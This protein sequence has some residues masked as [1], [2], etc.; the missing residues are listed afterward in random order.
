MTGPTP[1]QYPVRM[2]V[3]T[4][5]NY[6]FCPSL[7]FACSG[8]GLHLLTLPF[9]L[10]W[11]AIPCSMFCLC[12]SLLCLA[13]HNVMSRVTGTGRG[14]ASAEIVT[15]CSFLVCHLNHNLSSFTDFWI[16]YKGHFPA[17]FS[18]HKKNQYDWSFQDLIISIKLRIPKYSPSDIGRAPTSNFKS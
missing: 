9:S 4:C 5:L 12:L 2:M 3:L 17:F 6:L 18:G 10:L 8:P 14:S 7:W 16:H 1:R 15:S 11:S 13:L